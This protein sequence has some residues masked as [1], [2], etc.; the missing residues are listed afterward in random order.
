MS[1]L[2]EPE[3]GSIWVPDHGVELLNYKSKNLCP[4]R[5]LCE[6]KKNTF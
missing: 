3:G 1:S 2:V 6:F 5:L 4:N